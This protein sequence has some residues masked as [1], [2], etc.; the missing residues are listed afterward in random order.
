MIAELKPF[1]FGIDE[2]DIS[3]RK[4]LFHALD[5]RERT[6]M[7]FTAAVKMQH[8]LEKNHRYRGCIRID[9]MRSRCT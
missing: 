9:S 5:I 4:H 1:V 3:G 8:D 2:A 7:K 6:A